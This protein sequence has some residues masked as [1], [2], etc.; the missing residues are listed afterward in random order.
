[1]PR[2]RELAVALLAL[3]AS[4]PAF[5]QSAGWR[6]R[7]IDGSSETSFAASVAALQNELPP[8]RREDFE[9]ALTAIWVSKSVGSAGL[10]RDADGDVDNV[11]RRLL[12]EETVRLLTGLRR[13]DLLASIEKRQANADDDALAELVKQLDGSTY[14]EVLD[15]A[16]RFDRLDPR[17]RSN[18]EL[19]LADV[20]YQQDALSSARRH[21]KRAISAGG[22]SEQEASDVRRRL[23]YVDWRLSVPPVIF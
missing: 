15:L 20:S 3:A 9:T 19:I 23:S 12:A 17:A 5:A 4:A 2:R 16:G 10:D 7:Q 6:D 21:L 22:L 11:D 1:M 8:R 13:G 14:H 18:V